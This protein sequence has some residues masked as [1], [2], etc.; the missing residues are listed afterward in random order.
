MEQ[1][2]AFQAVCA[3]VVAAHGGMPLQASGAALFGT[4][5]FNAT[6][7][8]NTGSE[9]YPNGAFGVQGTSQPFSFHTGGAHFLMGDGAVR[10]VPQN[11]DATVRLNMAAM[12]DG[13][14]VELP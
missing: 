12:M 10:F 13:K 5:P 2:T 11:T 1:V 8:H 7:G 6:N 3:E 9:S 14:Y 4:T